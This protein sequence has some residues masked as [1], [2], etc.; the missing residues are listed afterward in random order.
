MDLSTFAT[1]KKS[2]YLL[3]HYMLDNMSTIFLRACNEFVEFVLPQD[4]I[5]VNDQNSVLP[6]MALKLFLIGLYCLGERQ[7]TCML[8]NDT[9][10]FLLSMALGTVVGDQHFYYSMDAFCNE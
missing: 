10:S 2:W 4:K 8:V 6:W 7:H 1:V 3:V 9:C 5:F